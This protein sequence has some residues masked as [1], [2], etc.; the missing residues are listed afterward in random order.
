MPSL[1]KKCLFFLSI[2]ILSHASSP[3]VTVHIMG[4]FGNQL[5]Q[6]AAAYAYSLDHDMPL[7]IPQLTTN[8]APN[9][10]YNA[11]K[12]LL[13]KI[14]H[15]PLPSMPQRRWNEPSF[16]Y[17]PIPTAPSIELFGYFQSEKYF[18]HRREDILQLFAPPEDLRAA[19][20]QKYPILQSDQLVV[21][22]QIRDY[23]PDQPT[24]A[25]HPNKPRSYYAKAINY[26]PPNT[27]F[28]VSSNNIQWAKQ[29]VDGLSPHLIYLQGEDYIEDFYALSLCDSFIIANSSFGWWASYLSTSPNKVV[30]AP[31]IWFSPPY[32]NTAM[33]K[34]IY[35]SGCL[36]FDD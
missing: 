29:C 35:P 21:G 5:F 2:A 16:T 12:I 31:K 13:H 36:V 32:N 34:D 11:K 26:F 7:I 14:A 30:I 23:R 9:L 15:T 3:F 8:A 4:Q 25:F 24:G 22:I 20:L 10:A 6:I 19:I 1:I 33:T 28:L 17:H 18:H 27:V